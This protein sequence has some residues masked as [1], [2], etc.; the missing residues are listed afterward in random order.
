VTTEER[1]ATRSSGELV[2]SVPDHFPERDVR[3]KRP[4]A[5]SFL[6][7]ME[8]FRRLARVVSLL[9]IDLIGVL[10]A[11]FTALLVKLLLQGNPDISVAWH[12][13]RQWGLFAY[14]VTV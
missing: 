7:R 12:D 6:L 8:T 11:L 14:L 10:G 9:I 4:P 1:Q 5:F 13:T 3:R 2:G